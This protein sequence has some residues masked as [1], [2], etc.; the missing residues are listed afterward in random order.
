MG[1]FEEVELHERDDQPERNRVLQPPADAEPIVHDQQQN[2]DRGGEAGR[3]VEHRCGEFAAESRADQDRCDRK[4][5]HD[6]HAHRGRPFRDCDEG[7]C[8]SLRQGNGGT[9]RRDKQDRAAP[10]T[11]GDE[12]QRGGCNHDVGC[13]GCERRA[14]ITTG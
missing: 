12:E 13:D 3:A 9:E 5:Q 10:A 11:N 8:A 7:R 2:R 14:F 1:A 4:Q 6:R